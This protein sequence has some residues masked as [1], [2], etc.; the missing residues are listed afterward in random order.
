[1]LV[2]FM[3]L[4]LEFIIVFSTLEPNGYAAGVGTHNPELYIYIIFYS[5]HMLYYTSSILYVIFFG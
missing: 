5:M 3:K 1:M 4:N 2:Q